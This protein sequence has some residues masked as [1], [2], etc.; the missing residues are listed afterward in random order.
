MHGLP[1]HA[2]PA[3]QLGHAPYRVNGGVE[4]CLSCHDHVVTV[5][6]ACVNTSRTGSSKWRVWTNV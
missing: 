4:S 6:V 1:L 2:H 3:R 5:F